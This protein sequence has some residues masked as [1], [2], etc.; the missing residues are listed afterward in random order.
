MGRNVAAP[1]AS[2]LAEVDHGDPREGAP[3]Q[4]DRV[5]HRHPGH[6]GWATRRTRRAAACAA[7]GR[8]Y[9]T[10]CVLVCEKITEDGAFTNEIEQYTI[11]E[12]EEMV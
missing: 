7:R 4:V 11:K 8:R 2:V 9:A 10:Y 6:G 12:L 5:L 1:A 3:R